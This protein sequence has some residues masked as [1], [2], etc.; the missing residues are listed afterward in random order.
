MRQL[1]SDHSAKQ[2]FGLWLTWE[3]QVRNRNLSE[4]FNA[5]L[6]EIIEPGGHVTRYARS[7]YRTIQHLKRW[8]GRIVFVQNPSIVLACIATLFRPIFGYILI[9]DAHNAGIYPIKVK[10]IADHIIKWLLRQANFTIVTNQAL[11]KRVITNGGRPLIIPD[12]LPNNIGL[13]R[14]Q[15]PNKN[16]KLF[17]VLFICTWAADEPYL[18]VMAAA[19]LVDDAH[20]FIT[21]SSKGREKQFLRAIPRNVTLT[22]Y[23][24]EQEYHQLLLDSDIIIDLTTRENCLVCGAYEAVAAEKPFVLS[25]TDALQIYFCKG[26]VH[27]DNHAEAIAMGIKAL[28]AQYDFYLD[29]IHQFKSELEQNWSRQ[30]ALVLNEIKNH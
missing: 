23:V 19:E 21:G 3:K 8:R 18:E 16:K 14:P 11:V 1:S 4:R 15:V 20:I 2:P 5:E 28:V 13:P 17:K 10:I 7:I 30:F 27:V 25:K 22:G 6:V 24:P 29:E 12:P 9:V 26:G